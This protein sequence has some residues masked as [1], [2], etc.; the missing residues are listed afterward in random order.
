MV[1]TMP[2]KKFV[3]PRLKLADTEIE[4][5]NQF[6]FLGIAL[7]NHL[8]WNAHINKLFGKISRTTGVLNKIKLFLPSRILKNIYSSLIL[9]QLNYGI[10]AWGQ[11]YKRVFKL[12]K[13]AIRI[14][15]C[16]RYNAHYEPLFK[17]LKLLKVED[18]LKLQQ[19]KLYYKLVHRQL[20]S[21]FNCYTYKYNSST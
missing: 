21:Y 12:Q 15:T 13:R 1:F 18:I 8:N 7:D 20:P 10:L 3:V 11:N 19:L 17:E 4:V 16:S 14:I 5:V 2:Q 9:C 6:N